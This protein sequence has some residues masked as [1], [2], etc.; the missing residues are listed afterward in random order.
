MATLQSCCLDPVTNAMRLVTDPD[1]V[2]AT[3]AGAFSGLAPA[4]P[5]QA[6]QS[7]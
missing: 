6:R 7:C 5:R 1:V 4:A 3:P 2:V